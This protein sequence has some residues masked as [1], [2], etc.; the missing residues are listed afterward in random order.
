MVVSENECLYYD[1]DDFNEYVGNHNPF[2]IFNQNIRSFN[3]N[4]DTL[5][6]FLSNINKTVEIIVLTETWFTAGSCCNIEGYR[7]YHS[8]RENKTGGGVSIFVKKSI[9]SVCLTELSVSTDLCEACAVEIKPNPRNSKLN[10]II[11]GLY[12]PPN[13]PKQQFM[14]YVLDKSQSFIN[15]SVLYIGDLNID[16]LD[17]NS[18]SDFINAMYSK[19]FF[20]LIN[21]PTRVTENSATCLDH[22]WY[23]SFN[24]LISGSF[25]L[26]VSDHYLAFTTLNIAIDNAPIVQ[27]FRD[28]SNRNI[29]RLLDSMSAFHHEY[30]V[31]LMNMNVN[32]KAEWFVN[33]LWKLYNQ[34]CPKRTKTVSYKTFVKPWITNEIKTL[35]KEKHAL[36]KTYKC[37]GID[38]ETYNSHKNRVSKI[39]KRAKINYYSNKF[40][41]V[42]NNIKKCWKTINSI[43]R[44]ERKKVESVVLVNDDGREVWESEDVSEMFCD[45]FSRIATDLDNDIPRSN[46][47]PLSYLPP[48]ADRSFF[49]KHATIDEINKIIMSLPNKGCDINAIP[50][51]IYK[52]LSMYLSP[53]ICDIFNSSVSEGI[54]PEILKIARVVPIHK[55]KSQSLVKNYRPI[56]VLSILA[57]LLEKLMKSRAEHFLT[58][59]SVLY[60]NQFGFRSNYSTSDPVL[61]FIDHC[62][63]SLDKKV[64]TIAVFL[65]FSKAFD[66]VNK[67]IMIQKLEH[68]G[69]RGVIA[70]WFDS[71]L[72]DRRMY[73]DINGS[74]SRTRT[75]NIGLPQG[76]V[77]SP[78]LFS[79]YI[80]DMHRC[81]DKLSFLHF[82]DDTTVYMSGSDLE[83]LC[84]DVSEE[85]F[86]VNEWLKANRLS[87][88]VDKSSF[89]LFTHSQ[90]RHDDIQIRLG[91]RTINQVKSI[92]FLGIHIDNR[93]SFNDHI[94]NLARK[95]SQTI[96]IMYKMSSFVPSNILKMI[97]FSLFYPHLIY[98]I[99]IWGG[100]GSTNVGK[101]AKLQQRALSLFVNGTHYGTPLTYNSVYLYFFVV[102]IP[103]VSLS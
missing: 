5:A 92:K 24:T 38:F 39:L 75:I 12:K 56:S 14:E 103:K 4:Y 16:I 65:D 68:V 9:I 52:K 25:V 18:N 100:C 55:N 85:L 40:H 60:S 49:A 94:A 36:F 29:C 46:T 90:A 57:K 73:V 1:V 95:L 98:G 13:S 11:L 89:M 22:I 54:F 86:K 10:F 2:V 87:L 30:N 77:T 7:G 17:E 23:N 47:D 64:H 83:R 63:H 79:L 81:S 97:Y 50:I 99:S 59:T 31:F 61:Q 32:R 58:S 37:G 42:K 82:A 88:N 19:H 53:I 76:S 41:S 34:H 15:K 102:S 91:D 44:T 6:S 62:G 66:T 21:I 74:H 27:T 51:F 20:P 26:D 67:N 35:I 45:Y 8:Y 69:F 78:W 72:S 96:G 71:Y 43:F 3:Q 70:N 84:V 48:R 101:I 80:N 93:L 33:S 28:H